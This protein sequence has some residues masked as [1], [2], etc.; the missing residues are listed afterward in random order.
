MILSHFQLPFR[1]GN[2]GN[3]SLGSRQKYF[4]KPAMF[5]IITGAINLVFKGKIL[6][7]L[8]LAT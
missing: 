7:G 3:L 4:N 6:I 8:I 2:T 5:A 1:S